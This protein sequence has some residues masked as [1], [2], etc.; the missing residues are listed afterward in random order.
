MT[1]K[2]PYVLAERLPKLR[3]AFIDKRLGFQN[4]Y[5][6]CYYQYPDKPDCGCAVGVTLT[7][8]ELKAVF[9]DGLNTSSVNVLTSRILTTDLEDKKDLKTLQRFHDQ[10]CY[11]ATAMETDERTKLANFFLTILN[12][13]LTKHGL[14]QVPA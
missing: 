6:T 14:E 4:G 5:S 9:D 2:S 3:Q 12:E 8:E 1:V 7:P 11:S 13:L 10:A